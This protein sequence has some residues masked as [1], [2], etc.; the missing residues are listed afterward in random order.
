MTPEQIESALLTAEW[1]GR[2]SAQVGYDA[3]DDICAFLE[4]PDMGPSLTAYEAVLVALATRAK[5]R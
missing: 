5:S 2:V 4:L 3:M 1:Y